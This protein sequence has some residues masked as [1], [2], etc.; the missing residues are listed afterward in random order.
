MLNV[1]RFVGY[2]SLVLWVLLAVLYGVFGDG[3]YGVY[4]LSALVI[5][6]AVWLMAFIQHH[7]EMSQQDIASQ[8]EKNL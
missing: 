6:P 8:A 1:T 5:V 4:L 2:V 3:K 7:K